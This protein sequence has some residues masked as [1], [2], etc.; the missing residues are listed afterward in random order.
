MEKVTDDPVEA[1][2]RIPQIDTREEVERCMNGEWTVDLARQSQK[3]L[4]KI[5]R[6][7]KEKLKMRKRGMGA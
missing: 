6:D 2:I 7:A 1:D 3:P 5:T 4:K